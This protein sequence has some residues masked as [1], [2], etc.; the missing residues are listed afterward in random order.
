[1]D[2]EDTS[3]FKVPTKI[4]RLTGTCINAES[5]CTQQVYGIGILLLFPA[6]VVVSHVLC[7][8]RPGTFEELS[9]LILCFLSNFGIFMKTLNFT[10]KLRQ[11]EE[12]IDLSQELFDECADKEKVNQKLKTMK[13]FVKVYIST[14]VTATLVSTFKCAYELPMPMWLPFEVDNN[15]WFYWTVAIYQSIYCNVFGLVMAVVDFFPLFFVIYTIGFLEVL[16]NRLESLKTVFEDN[17]V[18][19]D[20]DKNVNELKKCIKFQEKINDCIAKVVNTFSSVLLLQGF[21]STFI[22][23]FTAFLLTTVSGKEGIKFKTNVFP[24]TAFT[25]LHFLCCVCDYNAASDLD[26][27]SLR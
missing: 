25:D 16:Q 14:V 23:C 15:Q 22:L 21:S 20:F 24:S 6:L 18:A 4:L 3:P 13:W 12:L 5:S 9:Y 8:P 10:V 27:L 19:Q 11:I 26:P 7:F 1:M 2:F 17:L